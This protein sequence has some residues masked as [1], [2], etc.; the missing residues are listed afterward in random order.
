[1]INYQPFPTDVISI[2]PPPDAATDPRTN[3][4][5]LRA[6][7]ARNDG[8]PFADVLTEARIHDSL[9]EHGV[10]YRDR[11]FSRV[12]VWRGGLGRGLCSLLAR[13]FVCGCHIIS[14]VL[15]LHTPLIK[16]DGRFSRIRLSDKAS[17]TFAHE[18]SPLR[19]LKLVQSQLLVQVFVRVADLSRTPHLELHAQPLT[20]PVAD[21]AVDVPVGLAHRPDAEIVGPTA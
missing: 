7:F 13:P 3:L 14:A 21:V 20:H 9:D 8:L 5:R 19:S 12:E 2:V 1:M 16:P 11:V 17:H 4:D 10:R 6:R 15:R 18:P